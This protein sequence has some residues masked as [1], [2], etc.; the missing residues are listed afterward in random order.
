VEGEP[1]AR[2]FGGGFDL[3]PYYG[4]EEDARHWHQTAQHAVGAERYPA[5]KAHCD[6]YFFLP[7]RQE[8]RG[9]G[10]L[11]FDDWQEGGFEPSFALMRAV[12][13]AFWPAYA[14]RHPVRPAV[15]RTQRIH[16]HVAA[17]ERA[18]ELRPGPGAGQRGRAASERISR[19]Q[20]LDLIV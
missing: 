17:A 13:D 7:H 1:P 4:F 2:W 20:R 10:G 18:V 15:G 16:P 12:G 5:F 14:P 6:R 3:T 8:P 9:I 19:R 11:F